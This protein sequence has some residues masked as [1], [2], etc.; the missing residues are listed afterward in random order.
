MKFEGVYKESL[1]IKLLFNVIKVYENIQ[2][3]FNYL[4]VIN[5]SDKTESLLVAKANNNQCKEFPTITNITLNL[6]FLQISQK[7]DE[8]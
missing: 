5:L 7:L 6:D 1:A 8:K 4:S 2:T 3:K